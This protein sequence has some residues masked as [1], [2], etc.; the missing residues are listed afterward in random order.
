M[1][2][3]TVDDLQRLYNTAASMDNGN[4][5]Y[6]REYVENDNLKLTKTGLFQN[7]N[8]YDNDELTK[9]SILNTEKQ[10]QGFS[11]YEY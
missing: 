10:I 5:V 9:I 7:S 4:N 11:L 8:I 6:T 3:L 2:S 1:T